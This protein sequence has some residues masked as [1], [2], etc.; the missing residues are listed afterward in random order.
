MHKLFILCCLEGWNNNENKSLSVISNSLFSKRSAVFENLKVSYVFWSF[1]TKRFM[2]EIFFSFHLFGWKKSFRF[3]FFPFVFTSNSQAKNCVLWRA[4]SC[5]IN[6]V[7]YTKDT[8]QY[9]VGWRVTNIVMLRFRFI[10]L[11]RTGN[12]G[13]NI[14]GK[15]DLFVHLIPSL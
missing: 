15:I 12:N 13:V 4:K 11:I 6:E 3:T 8:G 10:F 14:W 5:K 7:F 1:V 2:R 9:T